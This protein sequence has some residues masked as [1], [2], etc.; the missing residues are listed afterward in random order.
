MQL[1]LGDYKLFV[2]DKRT[3]NKYI[4]NISVSVSMTMTHGDDVG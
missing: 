3:I 4:G 2:G 1:N